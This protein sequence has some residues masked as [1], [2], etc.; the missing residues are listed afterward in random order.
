M[1]A[2]IGVPDIAIVLG[3]VVLLF[4]A[5][6][7]PKLARSLGEAQKEFKKGQGEEQGEGEADS[8]PSASNKPP[9]NPSA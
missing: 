1:L 9:S 6:R 7:I 8:P 3:V 2:L 4:G 5:A